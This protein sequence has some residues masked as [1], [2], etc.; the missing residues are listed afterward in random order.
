MTTTTQLDTEAQRLLLDIAVEAVR[1]RLE[2]RAAPTGR[3]ADDSPIPV[4]LAR[5]GASFVTLRDG[6]RLL[7]CV[8]SMAP[9]RPLATDVA[10]NAVSAAF[11]DP[12]MPAL[13]PAEFETME[14]KISVLS[15]L[16]PMPVH[17]LDELRARVVPGKDGLLIQSGSRRGTFL[18][19][20]WEQVPSV[21]EF[22]SMLW[23]KAGLPPGTWPADLV[24]ERYRTF[25][26]GDPGPR[27]AINHHDS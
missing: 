22:L 9:I 21:D 27:P 1:T 2:G 3:T 19:S 20:V 18:P 23:L 14:V 26:F 5:P 17:S 8:G 11:A 25:E 4:E 24:V 15:P 12:R 7:G 13:T 16:V 6:R 10:A